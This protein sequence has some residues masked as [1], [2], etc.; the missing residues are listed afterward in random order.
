VI[1]NAGC[2]SPVLKLIE[3]GLVVCEIND[4]GRSDISIIHQFYAV[5]PNT[6]NHARDISL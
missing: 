1:D 5:Y 4:A 6:A 2:T 3:A